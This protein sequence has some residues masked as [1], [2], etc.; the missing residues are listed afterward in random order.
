MKK[1]KSHEIVLK[2]LTIKDANAAFQLFSLKEVA[3]FYDNKPIEHNES[4]MVFTYRIIK[5]S[6][7]IWKIT[8]TNEP[9]KLIGVCALHKWDATHKTI[10]IGGTLLP[11]WWN[12]NIMGTAF[13]QIIAF[14]AEQIGVQQILAR[15][16]PTNIQAIKLVEKLN[17]QQINLSVN[18]IFLSLDMQTESNIF[19]KAIHCLNQKG[20]I[21]YP[22]DTVW[23]LGCN[24]LSKAAINKINSIKDRPADKSYIILMKD[25]Q[26][27]SN[28]AH[29]DPE[30]IKALLSQTQKPTT[31][32]YHLKDKTLQHL[33]SEDNTIA[34]RIP[35]RGFAKELLNLID[36]PLISTSANL[37]GESN[38]STFQEISEAVKQQVDY[39]VPQRLVKKMDTNPKPS[40][41]LKIEPSG[42]II[43]IRE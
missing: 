31:I 28:I 35:K 36:F 24:A 10:E 42:E 41:I 11:E 22:T 34:I 8:L 32:I 17:F 18:E 14:A 21:L 38:P 30:K 20:S 43:T 40:T 26:C 27:I 3:D 7:Y 16:S 9:E 12:Q 2:P 39:I 25:L 4:A 37:S 29:F 13:K 33:A 6:N 23:G 1:I 19:Q 15:T 5:G